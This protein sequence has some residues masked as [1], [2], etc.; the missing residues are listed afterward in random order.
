LSFSLP[1]SHP[2]RAHTV[3]RRAVTMASTEAG[4][5]SAVQTNLFVQLTEMLTSI[6]ARMDNF[7]KTSGDGFR[8]QDEKLDPHKAELEQR[9]SDGFRRQ[10]EKLDAH[11]AELEQRMTDG[12]RRQDE[13]LDAHK[14]ELE[15]KMADRHTELK[16]SMKTQGKRLGEL[17]RGFGALF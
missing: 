9:M 1:L 14:A 11:K 4:P 12:F 8:R 16:N 17:I 15:K 10:D 7:E 5:D 13:K 3:A 2:L 6:N